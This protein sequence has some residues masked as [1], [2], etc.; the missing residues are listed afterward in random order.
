MI[1]TNHPWLRMPLMCLTLALLLPICAQAEG[2]NVPMSGAMESL[3]RQADATYLSRFGTSVNKLVNEDPMTLATILGITLQRQTNYAVANPQYG[4]HY[5]KLRSE[6]EQLLAYIAKQ[7]NYKNPAD[8]SPMTA[9]ALQGEFYEGI[10]GASNQYFIENFGFDPA[11][12]NLPMI[13]EQVKGATQSEPVDASPRL[14]TRDEDNTITLGGET[15]PPAV[16]SEPQSIKRG[17]VVYVSKLICPQRGTDSIKID[18]NNNPND[19]V[20]VYCSYYA[21]GVLNNQKPLVGKKRHG[22]VYDFFYIKDGT[23]YLRSK[24]PYT[25]SKKDGTCE[26]YQVKNGRTYLSEVKEFSDGK[27]NGLKEWYDLDESGRRYL[28]KVATYRNGKKHGKEEFFK[29]SSSGRRYREAISEYYNGV[30]HGE[31]RAFTE[32]QMNRREIYDNGALVKYWLY[33][34]KT[35]KLRGV[36]CRQKSGGFRSCN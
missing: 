16:Y 23:H 29:I 11:T 1:S 8:G 14:R 25:M 19:D 4:D 12:V 21:D 5:W 35:G 24:R 2:Q 13:L 26:I 17:S 9:E 28:R 18:S 15:A 10:S 31:R 22:V 33:N 34:G 32:Y 20:Y 27:L 3:L 30:Q 36:W 6:C 7:M